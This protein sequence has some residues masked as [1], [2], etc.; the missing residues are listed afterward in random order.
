MARAIPSTG[1]I[2][3]ISELGRAILGLNSL[4]S[5]PTSKSETGARERSVYFLSQSGAVQC[6]TTLLIP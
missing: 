4:R 6:S 2:P 3:K 5:S 1:F